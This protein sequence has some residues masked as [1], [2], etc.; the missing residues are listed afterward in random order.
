MQQRRCFKQFL[1]LNERLD[2][3]AER[4]R[5]EAKQLPHGVEEREKLIRKARQTETAAHID[6]WLSIARLASAQMKDMQVHLEK[7]RTDAAECGLITDPTKRELFT[8]LAAHLQAFAIDV[9][10]AASR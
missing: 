6:E 10:I 7:L 2:Q 3:E 5:T 1:S 9:D 4:L 8:R